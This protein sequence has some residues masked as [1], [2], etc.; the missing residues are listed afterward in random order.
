MGQT[1]KQV[2]SISGQTGV[3][4]K[5]SRS[6]VSDFLRP[7][8]LQPSRLLCPWD[9]PGN[10]TEVDCHFLLKGIF[11]TQGSKPGLLHCRPTLYHLSFWVASNS[12][13][14]P[15][16]SSFGKCNFLHSKHVY[17]STTPSFSEI[18]VWWLTCLVTMIKTS[19]T[20]EGIK[21]QTISFFLILEESY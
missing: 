21:K 14:L 18:L 20:K 19:S 16:L 9:F 15:S 11:P 4:M 7:H 2:W 6:V 5:W 3:S 17:S 13:S 8:R 12:F 10:S 1:K